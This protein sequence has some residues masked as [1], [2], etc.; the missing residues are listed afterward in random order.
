MRRSYVDY[1]MEQTKHLF[2]IDIEMVP[3]TFVE[4]G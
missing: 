2:A 4:F 3:S 1:Y